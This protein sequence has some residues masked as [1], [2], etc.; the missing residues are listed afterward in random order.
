MLSHTFAICAYQESPYLEACIRSLKRQSVPARIILCTSTPVPHIRTLAAAYD[1]E[2]FVRAGGSGIQEDW[3]FAYETAG[4]RLVTIAHQDDIYHRD[5]LKTVQE[6]WAKYPDIT[7]F[8]TDCAV[9][10]DGTVQKPGIIQLVKLLLRLPL[11]LHALAGRPA[12]KKLPLRFGNPIICP[13]CTYDKA[14]LGV[15]LFTS[16]YEFAL[17]WDTMWK[18]A[19]RPGRFFCVEK[20]LIGYRIHEEA[21]TKAC[22]KS[23]RR[24]QEETE[25]YKK[26]WPQPLVRILMLFYKTA[27]HAYD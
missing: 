4:T 20:P 15:P 10:R 21:A 1:I 23:R 13:S 26:M 24:L 27:Y 19:E 8:H 7:V 17:D 3:N 12:I 2:L 22:I 9:I 6:S 16:A 11:R 5:Y 18:L 25:M 14:A